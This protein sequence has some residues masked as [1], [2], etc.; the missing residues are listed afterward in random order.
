M[1]RIRG[2]VKSGSGNASPNFRKGEVESS[3]AGFL[4][5]PTVAS[6][7]LNVHIAQEY[8]ALDN[9]VY[10]L[11][12]PP[13]KYNGRE[14]VK[15][16]KC[17]VN[18]VKCVILRAGDHFEVPKFRKRIEIMSHFKLR[19]HLGLVDGSAVELEFQGDDAWWN[20][21]GADPGQ[22]AE[23]RSGAVSEGAR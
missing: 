23:G 12:L 11:E 9:G 5:V 14:F 3:V 1:I 6:G 7:T 15:I 10:D 19:D 17:K 2:K 16:K 20:G 13:S 22:S 8:A 18:G 21:T 4:E